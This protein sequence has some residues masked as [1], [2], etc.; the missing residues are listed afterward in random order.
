MQEHPAKSRG[1]FTAPRGGLNYNESS[2]NDS[3]E[4]D[5]GDEEDVD[6]ATVSSLQRSYD[7][8]GALFFGRITS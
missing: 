3:E 5:N 6:K 1:Q 2:M 8:E 7:S 4:H